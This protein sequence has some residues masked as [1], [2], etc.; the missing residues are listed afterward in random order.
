[1]QNDSDF[2]RVSKGGAVMSLIKKI[3]DLSGETHDYEVVAYGLDAIC[4]GILSMGI[5]IALG[6]GFHVLR[7]TL[8]FIACNFLLARA[9]GKYHATTRFRCHVLTIALWGVSITASHWCYDRIPWECMMATYI[10]YMIAVLRWAPVEHP[11]KPLDSDV[12]QKNKRRSVIYMIISGILI[13]IFWNIEK[14]L[15]YVLWINITEIIITMIIGKEAYQN[16]H[17]KS[18]SDG[19]QVC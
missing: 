15:S 9:T 13:M 8:I 17:D 11:Q 14:K 10:I 18:I 1:L 4:S 5:L 2:I 7:E 6:V 3:I 16:E 12:L 19:H